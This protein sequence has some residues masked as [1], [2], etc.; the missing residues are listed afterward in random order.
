M[1]TNTFIPF[2][3][4]IMT[5]SFFF[6]NKKNEVELYNEIAVKWRGKCHI[7][8]Y[9]YDN[10]HAMSHVFSKLPNSNPFWSNENN[11]IVKNVFNDL[12]LVFGKKKQQQQ[13]TVACH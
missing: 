8:P 4:I 13:S 11:M 1:N 6:A 3:I 10:Y 12:A 9:I 2:A 5:M 7:D